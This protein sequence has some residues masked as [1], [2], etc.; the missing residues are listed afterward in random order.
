MDLVAAHQVFQWQ[1]VTH[2][3]NAIFG[4]GVKTD[5]DWV[6]CKLANANANAN[7]AVSLKVGRQDV[8]GFEKLDQEHCWFQK[9]TKI[10]EVN[11]T[12][13]TAQNGM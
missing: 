4:K 12:H 10:R 7:E 8:G 6:G 13:P 5:H 3:K 9:S 11:E 1:I 2:G